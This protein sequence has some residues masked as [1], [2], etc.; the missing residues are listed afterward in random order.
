ML[1]PPDAVV[2]AVYQPLGDPPEWAADLVGRRVAW[3]PNPQVE[4]GADVGDW[5]MSPYPYAQTAPDEVRAV[6]LK[7]LQQIEP[8]GPM[9]SCT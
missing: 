6:P 4:R 2:F 1:L 3:T 7:H 8:S 9:P 5:A